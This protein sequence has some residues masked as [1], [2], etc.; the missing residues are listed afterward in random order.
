MSSKKKPKKLTK[1]Q[2]LKRLKNQ[3]YKLWR[4]CVLLK[5]GYKCVVCGDTHLPNCHH[6][7]P[8][9]FAA[10]RYDPDNGIIFCPRHHKFNNYFSAHKNSL[11]FIVLL[12]QTVSIQVIRYLIKVMQEQGDK[13]IVPDV[14]Y[15]EEAIRKLKERKESYGSQGNT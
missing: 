7:V 2:L 8:R 11:W 3:A 13:K 1:K 6:I 9:I 5:F 14:A 4:E 10:L 15:Y 12:V